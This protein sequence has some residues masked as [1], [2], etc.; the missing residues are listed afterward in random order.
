MRAT[1]AEH[2]ILYY[3]K[4]DYNIIYCDILYYYYYYTILEKVAADY[5]AISVWEIAESLGK[6]RLVLR[7]LLLLLFI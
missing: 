7:L 6:W 1:D 5:E 2:T 4:L 3:T